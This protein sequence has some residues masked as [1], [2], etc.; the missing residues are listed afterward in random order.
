LHPEF[1][2]VSVS[3]SDL[4]EKRQDKPFCQ[5]PHF[6]EADRPYPSRTLIQEAELLLSV[7]LAELQRQ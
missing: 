4:A 1:P 3:Q 6:A 2:F 7:I 5:W